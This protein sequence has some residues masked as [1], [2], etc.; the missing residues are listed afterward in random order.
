MID[1][2]TGIVAEV[3]EALGVGEGSCTPGVPGKGGPSSDK[4][5]GM[6]KGM[7]GKFYCPPCNSTQVLVIDP[8]TDG[9]YKIGPHYD[10]DGKWGNVVEAPN[11]KLYSPPRNSERVLTIDP[12]SGVVKEIGPS[13]GQGGDKWSGIQ[14]GSDGKLYCPPRGAT[15]VLAIDPTTDDVFEILLSPEAEANL[16]WMCAAV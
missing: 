12:S 1:P 16:K 4:W 5:W 2:A 14:V 11:G 8:E 3:G 6:A 10:G 7:D 13:F 15:S 9:V